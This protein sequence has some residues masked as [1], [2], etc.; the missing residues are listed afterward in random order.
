MERTFVILKP[1]CME[2]HLMPEVLKRFLNAG[3]EIVACKMARIPEEILREHYAHIVDKPY[4][5]PLVEFMQRKPVI[6][7]VLEGDS[8]VARVRKLLGC[9]SSLEAPA[10]T[11]R[12]D[13]GLNSRENIAHASD[14]AE[15]ANIEIARFFIP[16][17]IF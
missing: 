9:T 7:M 6:L 8:A 11:I 14:C 10:G 5:P 4:Y 17:E 15:N 1:D 12:G 2:R 13:F 16:E 3:L